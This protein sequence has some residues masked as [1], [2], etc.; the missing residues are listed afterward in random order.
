MEVHAFSTR[1]KVGC[2]KKTNK[3]KQNWRLWKKDFELSAIYAGEFE[4]FVEEKKALEMTAAL[5]PIAR[6]HPRL[7]A[8]CL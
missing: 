7:L 6:F 5:E 3:R 4:I 2:Q 8:E 1:P